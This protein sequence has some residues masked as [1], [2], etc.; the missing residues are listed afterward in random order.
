MV[1]LG[2]LIMILIIIKL[3][4][5]EIGIAK[6]TIAGKDVKAHLFEYTTCTMVQMGPDMGG[7]VKASGIPIQIM[8]C[9]KEQ[10]MS[11]LPLNLV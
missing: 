5:A 10:S 4:R 1:R 6:D 2:L 8:F 9:L 3:S 11:F 7:E